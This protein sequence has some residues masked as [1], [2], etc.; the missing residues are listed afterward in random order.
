M[1]VFVYYN[2]RMR[3][4]SV[5]ARSGPRAGRVIL[6][7]HVVEIHD[8]RMHVNDARRLR[9]IAAGRKNVHAGVIGVLGDHDQDVRAVHAAAI[10]I[11]YNPN[12]APTFVTLDGVPIAGA[13]RVVLDTRGSWA[14]G[15]R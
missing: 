7:A 12:K 1:Q 8:A 15:A 9:G 5:L 11:S 10:R 13:S 2:I 6:R 14:E 4:F 3:T